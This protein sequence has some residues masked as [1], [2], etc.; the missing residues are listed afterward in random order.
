MHVLVARSVIPPQPTTTPPP[1]ALLTR[2]DG[3][4]AEAPKPLGRGLL[5]QIN[6]LVYT[7]SFVPP[8]GNPIVLSVSHKARPDEPATFLPGTD[9][10]PPRWVWLPCPGRCPRGTSP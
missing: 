1:T 8:A 3:I 6:K 7:W 2:A 9:S 10:L 4:W 5:P